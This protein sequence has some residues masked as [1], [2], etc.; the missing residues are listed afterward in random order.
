MELVLKFFTTLIERRCAFG[1]T[2]RN[3]LHQESS[4]N[5]G[6]S[7]PM[8]SVLPTFERRAQPLAPPCASSSFT[9]RV[10]IDEERCRSLR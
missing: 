7:Q 3:S 4:L 6:A 1:L 10:A 9:W 8:K 2:W 5:C